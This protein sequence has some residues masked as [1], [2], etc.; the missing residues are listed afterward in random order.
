MDHSLSH[1]SAP[2]RS[3]SH[4]TCSISVPQQN[5]NVLIPEKYPLSPLLH[6]IPTPQIPLRYTSVPAPHCKSS[7]H[8]HSILA[9]LHPM[10]SKWYF[11]EDAL[12]T[13]DF[14]SRL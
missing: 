5:Q 9:P 4:E 6:L 1:K 10:S 3:S 8:L 2:H 13:P 14:L 11:P 12:H 7:N